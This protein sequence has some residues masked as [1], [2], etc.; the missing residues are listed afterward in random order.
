MY[1]KLPC[2]CRYGAMREAVAQAAVQVA[3]ERY[4]K[5]HDAGVTAEGGGGPTPEQVAALHEELHAVLTEEL[6][7]AF[8]SASASGAGM[9]PSVA[10][11]SAGS[12]GSAA[13][14]DAE[15]AQLL[16]LADECEQSGLMRRAESLHQV[17][18]EVA[19]SL[20]QVSTEVAESLHQ[21][22]TE[23]A[24]P[25][26]QRWQSPQGEGQWGSEHHR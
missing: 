5:A 18:T 11:G 22:S 26:R 19:E 9:E 13:A 17:S 15:L 10:A 20:H 6:A 4:G 25:L 1:T 16:M 8:A 12:A 2:P 3:L 21:V 14:K 7:S 24:D 23:V